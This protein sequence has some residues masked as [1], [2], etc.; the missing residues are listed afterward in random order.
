MLT[1]KGECEDE[2]KRELRITK[3]GN[4]EAKSKIQR[5]RN[6]LKRSEKNIYLIKIF[7]IDR[8]RDIRESWMLTTSPGRELEIPFKMV[9][10]DNFHFSN[11]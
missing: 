9:I 11:E 3:N 10:Y 4:T 5:D 6:N 2:I 1:N 7:S 8:P